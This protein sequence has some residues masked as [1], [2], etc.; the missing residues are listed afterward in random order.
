M[1]TRC[2]SQRDNNT[3]TARQSRSSRLRISTTLPAENKVVCL[4]YCF[5]LALTHLLLL[6][7]LCYCFRLVFSH[8]L[9]IRLCHLLR[10]ALIMMSYKLRHL[11]LGSLIPLLIEVYLPSHLESLATV[12]TSAALNRPPVNHSRS[13]IDWLLLV[14]ASPLA[15]AYRHTRPRLAEKC[16]ALSSSRLS[17]CL[18]YSSQAATAC[19]ATSMAS[20]SFLGARAQNRA[21]LPI[22]RVKERHLLVKNMTNLRVC[23]ETF[24]ARL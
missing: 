22:Q 10:I 3:G 18:F 4:C 11:C 20:R 24:S 15:G 17:S 21:L 16:A 7:C 23:L 1:A 8:S 6:V 9:P 5:C 13:C 12:A 19:S 2:T 14:F